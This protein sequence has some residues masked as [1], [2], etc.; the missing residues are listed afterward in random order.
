ENV[1]LPM[2]LGGMRARAAHKRAIDALQRVAMIE[3]RNQRP[4]QLTLGEQQRVAVARA[5]ANLPRIVWADEPTGMLDTEN[6]VSLMKLFC[7]LHDQGETIVYTTH[8]A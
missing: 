6:A 5:V 4:E 7:E 2:L 8:D 1:E 3:R